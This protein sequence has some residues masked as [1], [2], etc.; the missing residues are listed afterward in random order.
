ML[1]NLHRLVDGEE[2]AIELFRNQRLEKWN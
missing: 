2:E 1:L